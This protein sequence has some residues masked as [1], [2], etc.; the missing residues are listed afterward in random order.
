M[1]PWMANW[2][3]LFFRHELKCQEFSISHL[4]VPRP[5]PDVMV[6]T[7]IFSPNRCHDFIEPLQASSLAHLMC[8]SAKLILNWRGAG[9]CRLVGLIMVRAYCVSN[10]FTLV[11]RLENSL[12]KLSQWGVHN[13]HI[14]TSPSLFC[15]YSFAF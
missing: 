14:L 8:F 7:A 1:P 5:V 13:A 3:T 10:C 11:W 6:M 2:L 4:G 15:D 9:C 12:I